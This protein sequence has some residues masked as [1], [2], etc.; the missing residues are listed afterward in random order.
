MFRRPSQLRRSAPVQR[1]ERCRVETRA[2]HQRCGR[3]SSPVR[4]YQP[5]R[6]RG[7][8]PTRPDQTAKT[9][10]T[11]QRHP[12]AADRPRDA[13][14]SFEAGEAVAETRQVD[15]GAHGV[16]IPKAK[17]NGP[18]SVHSRHWSPTPFAG[19]VHASRWSSGCLQYSTIRLSRT[20]ATSLRREELIGGESWSSL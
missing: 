18:R 9:T 12:E 15:D 10:T 8:S 3:D 7:T 5:L 14:V 17:G 2:V 1:D 11:H 16:G 4:S 13:P 19:S 6:S 20:R